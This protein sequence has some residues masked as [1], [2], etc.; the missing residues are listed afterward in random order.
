[1]FLSQLTNS[2]SASDPD[3]TGITADSRL[4]KRGF[5]FAALPGSKGDGRDFIEAAIRHGASVILAPRG[6]VLPDDAGD[7]ITLITDDNP[8]KKFAHIASAFYNRQPDNIVA[9]TGTSGKTST[10]S[11]TQQLWHLA[12][13]KNCASLGTLGTRGPNIRKYGGMTT[14]DAQVMMAELADLSASGITHLAMEASSHGINQYRLDGVALK[15]AA[16]TNLS[17]DHLDYHPDMDHYFRSKA[18]LFTDLLPPEGVAVLPLDDEWGKKLASIVS[19]KTITLGGDIVV[20]KINAVPNGQFIQLTAFGKSYA[21]DLPLVGGFQVRNALTALALVVASGVDVDSAISHLAALR[22]I[23]GR[24]QLIEGHKDG[25]G[26]YV[27]YA[28]KPAAL[29]T[30]LRTLRP[31]TQGRLICVF[32][33]GGDRD[34]GKRPMMG[35]IAHDMADV[36][37]VTDDNPR[38]EDPATIRKQILAEA[39]DALEIGDRRK[40]IAE[41]VNMAKA[42]DVVVIAGKGHETGQIIGDKVEPFDDAQEAQKAIEG[43]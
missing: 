26:I 19:Q 34:P 36:V 32:G 1:M 40:A 23:E 24:L 3:V 38:S 9:V 13:I 8:R 2:K 30:I 42:G 15:A 41:A 22:K 25:A 17:R 28:H 31:H 37:I 18:R 33:C 39:P 20:Q 11:F 12:G 21:V 27:D 6:T 29:E 4:V 14:P 43:K 10:V 7:E 5:L 16:F 35:K